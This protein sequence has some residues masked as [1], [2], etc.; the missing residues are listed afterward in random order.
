[1]C[2]NEQETVLFLSTRTKSSIITSHIMEISTYTIFVNMKYWELFWY[3]RA[4]GKSSDNGT[5]DAGL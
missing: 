2:R 4:P 3:F 1:M 5:H